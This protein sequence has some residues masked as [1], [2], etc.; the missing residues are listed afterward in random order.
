MW[1]VDKCAKH[2]IPCHLVPYISLYKSVF[3]LPIFAILFANYLRNQHIGILHSHLYDTTLISSI[4][5]RLLNTG[6]VATL[7]DLYAIENNKA[8]ILSLKLSALLGSKIVA[9]SNDIK[10]HISSKSRF[11][12]NSLSVIYNGVNIERFTGSDKGDLARELGIENDDFIFICVARLV[13]LKNHR[14]L[15]DAFSKISSNDLSARLLLVGDGPLMRELEELIRRYNLEGNV[16]LLGQRDDVASLLNLSDCFVLASST[17]GLSCSIIEAMASG[18]PVIATDVG[19]NHELVINDVNGYLVPL[20]DTEGLAQKMMSIMKDR[21]MAKDA[22]NI[23]EQIARDKLS[24][25][26]MLKGY[27]ALY[28]TLLNDD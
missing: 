7:H 1:L 16:K 15:I 25:A 5:A 6:H 19:G 8:R 22:G 23:S 9:V 11:A 24:L 20:D 28:N 2:D 3:T 12:Q 26:Q 18:L 14:V 10:K 13:E 17:E 21:E 4:C 27:V